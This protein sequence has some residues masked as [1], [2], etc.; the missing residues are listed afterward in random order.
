MRH[1]LT[2]SQF[3]LKGDKKWVTKSTGLGF[4]GNLVVKTLPSNARD[5]GS[6]SGGELGS[7]LSG[8]QKT[9]TLKQKQYCNKW[10][11][12]KKKERKKNSKKTLKKKSTQ[13]L[14]TEICGFTHWLCNV[15]AL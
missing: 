15:T 3:S 13:A 5:V 11:T 14:Q 10:S 9:K 4:P 8:G 1:V 7:H 2:R 6:V 12:S